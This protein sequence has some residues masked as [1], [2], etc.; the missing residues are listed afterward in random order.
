[1][2]EFGRFAASDHGQGYFDFLTYLGMTPPEYGELDEDIRRFY[3]QAWNEKQ[4]RI[5]DEMD[6]PE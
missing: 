5:S 3:Q 4:R 6:A 1:M 2:I